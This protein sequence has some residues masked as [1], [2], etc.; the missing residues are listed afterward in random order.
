MQVSLHVPGGRSHNGAV[1]VGE[2]QQTG[3]YLGVLPVFIG[4]IDA[5]L[6]YIEG[7]GDRD[8]RLLVRNLSRILQV[9]GGCHQIAGIAQI[10]RQIDLVRLQVSPAGGR[11]NPALPVGI[12]HRGIV[13]GKQIHIVSVFPGLGVGA[14]HADR[15]F[16]NGILPVADV[17]GVKPGA[18]TGMGGDHV[19]IGSVHL[20]II[21]G[22]NN[23]K[24]I[25]VQI[26]FLGRM[27][28]LQGDLGNDGHGRLPAAVI[29]I[30]NQNQTVCL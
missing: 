15:A 6:A 11:H 7:G 27:I 17:I 20:R 12:Q 22:G 2:L 8:H 16:Q 19:L 30:H 10:L 21:L 23:G 18:H 5:L 26:N 13:P 25:P 1:P 9:H 3:A 24:M 28:R 29:G 4:N 14:V